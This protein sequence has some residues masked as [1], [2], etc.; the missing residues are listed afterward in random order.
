MQ[1]A[2]SGGKTVGD[3]RPKGQAFMQFCVAD[4][5]HGGHD[6][7]RELYIAH[8]E[9]EAVHKTAQYIH[10]K[11]NE[12]VDRLSQDKNL[13]DK[14][15]NRKWFFHGRGNVPARAIVVPGAEGTVGGW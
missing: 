5:R 11:A 10:S 2:A 7:L 8:L 13:D 3:Y 15:I 4:G 1:G 6:E 9:L 14:R 12:W